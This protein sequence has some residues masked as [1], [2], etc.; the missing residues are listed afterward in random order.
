[1]VVRTEKLELALLAAALAAAFFYF[2]LRAVFFD[3]F[4]WI[5]VVPIVAGL[6]LL[7]VRRRYSKM[8]LNAL[9]R[10]ALLYV[11]Y[12]AFM[13]VVAVLFLGAGEPQIVRVFVHYYFP[14]II[15]FIA[16]RYTLGSAA[17]VMNVTKLAWI[18]AAV[19]LADFFVELY[20]VEIRESGASIPWVRQEI[21]KKVAVMT[22]DLFEQYNSGR[23]ITI[24]NGLKRPGMAAAA[25]FVL[26]LPFL[27]TLRQRHREDSWFR[28]SLFNPVVNVV[29]L[30][31]LAF[32]AFH[33]QN[34]TAIL[35]AALALAIG[36]L[37]L[38]SARSLFFTSV[39]VAVGLLFAFGAIS[40][41]VRAQFL[42][43]VEIGEFGTST[44]IFA[45]TVDAQRVVEGYLESDFYSFLF[46]AHIIGSNLAN[47]TSPS[48]FSGFSE[49]RG[50]G[51]PIYFGF[52]WALL[53]LSAM[54]VAI[55]Y[56]T[57][58]TRTAQFKFFGLAFI[59]LV[60]V[61]GSDL[62]Y[63]SSMDH[64]PFELFLMMAGALSS[65]HEIARPARVQ[66]QAIIEPAPGLT[67][68]QRS[69]VRPSEAD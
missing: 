37:S 14:V 66:S 13:S 45:Y 30:G 35:A 59:G 12:G 25:L 34:K 2:P 24:L 49:L 57:R 8:R 20:V 47:A 10:I 58:L 41:L 46:G 9:D 44:T 50:T 21:V 48:S 68:E 28:S 23:V 52:G 51:F 63:P 7:T 65:L 69:A 6:Y 62:H 29:L 38:R 26:V 40:S 43:P 64:G 18:L 4:A 33:L 3:V 55:R 31:A 16:R 56:S 54:L 22:P 42:T 36:L 67:F 53:V 27:Y 5:I 1:M 15:Y 61:Y 11:M 32:M 17:N 19:L 39:L 60:V